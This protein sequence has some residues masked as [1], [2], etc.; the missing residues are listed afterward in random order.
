MRLIRTVVQLNHGIENSP[1]HR[2]QT[3]PDIRK[4]AGRNDAHRLIDIR[5]LH[6]LF[7]IHVM[8]FVKDIVFHSFSSPI[9]LFCLDIQVLYKL[10]V[11]LYKFTPRLYLIAH[12]GGKG[13]INL[14]G[15]R[16]IHCHSL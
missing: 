14:G 4:G 5:I 16:V 11:C 13:Q 9:P 8:E 15:I 3:I 1:L 10:R 2:L 12:Q 6:G 7:Q